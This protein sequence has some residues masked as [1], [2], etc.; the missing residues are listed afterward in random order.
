MCLIGHGAFG[1]IT[2]AVWAKYLG[3]A[4]IGQDTAYQ[5]MPVIGVADILLGIS[6]LLYPIRAVAGWLVI[7]GFATA[8]MRPLSGEPFAELIERAGN[9]GAPLALLVLCTPAKG[10]ASWFQRMHAPQG[11]SVYKLSQVLRV[12][13]AAAFLLLAGHGWL[14]LIGKEGLLSQYAALGFTD[15]KQVALIV[16]IIELAAACIIAFRPVRPFVLAVLI[17]KMTTEMFYPQWGFF[18]WVERGGSYGVLLAIWFALER[19]KSR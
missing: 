12:L 15:A 2:K 7:W 9:F 8:A 3:V 1:I 14:N 5:L 10:V 4:G 18:E 16:G 11:M 19:S 6:L 13:R 17:W